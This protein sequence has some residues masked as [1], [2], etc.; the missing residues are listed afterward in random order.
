MDAGG[1]VT[2][3]AVTERTRRKTKI[4]SKSPQRRKE[5]K[6]RTLRKT[7]QPALSMLTAEDNSLCARAIPVAFREIPPVLQKIFSLRPLRLC[8]E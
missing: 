8:G 5:R 7:R 6:V 3:G 2:H 1:R 4:K